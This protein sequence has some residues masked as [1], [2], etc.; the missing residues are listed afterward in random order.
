MY[1]GYLNYK[2][3]MKAN[4]YYGFHFSWKVCF[5]ACR[6]TGQTEVI[7]SDKNVILSFADNLWFNY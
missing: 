7:K 1:L 3:T 5:I 6:V 2:G 4:L